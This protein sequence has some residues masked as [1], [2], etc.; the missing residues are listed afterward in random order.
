MQR[1]RT[2]IEALKQLARSDEPNRD[3]VVRMCVKKEVYRLP[4]EPFPRLIFTAATALPD[5]RSNRWA[6][7]GKCLGGSVD[8][9]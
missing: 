6:G 1:R 7:P 4:R 5:G 2:C 9:K 8:L 3:Q